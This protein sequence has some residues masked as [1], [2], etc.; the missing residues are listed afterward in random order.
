MNESERIEFSDDYFRKVPPRRRDWASSLGLWDREQ[1]RL[2]RH[3]HE[4][5]DRLREAGYIDAHERFTFWPMNYELLRSGFRPDLFGESTRS[6]WTSLVDFGRAYAGLRVKAPS[7]EDPD[8]ALSLIQ[9]MMAKFRKLHARKAMLRRE[10]PVT[11]AYPAAVAL[12]CAWKTPVL[13]FP[14]VVAGEQKGDR[15]RLRLRRSRNTGGTLSVK[16]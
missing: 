10:L 11:V 9:Q 16:G 15:R 4:F 5:M 13:D 2:S 8:A 12:A 14:A 1:G 6:L 7:E 3:G